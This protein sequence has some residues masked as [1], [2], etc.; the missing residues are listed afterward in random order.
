MAS[1]PV[2]VTPI[3]RGAPADFAGTVIPIPE[4]YDPAYFQPRLDTDPP[5]MAPGPQMSIKNFSGP[6]KVTTQN[7]TQAFPDRMM[8]EVKAKKILRAKG[9]R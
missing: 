4:G 1:R 7:G 2:T 8:R 9:K 6:L 3:Q 5:Y